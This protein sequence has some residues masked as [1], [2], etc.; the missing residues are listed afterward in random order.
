MAVLLTVVSTDGGTTM[1]VQ[2]TVALQ[3]GTDGGD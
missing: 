1:V 2:L 3:V